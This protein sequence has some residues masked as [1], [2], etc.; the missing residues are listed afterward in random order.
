MTTEELRDALAARC[1]LVGWWVNAERMP[2]PDPRDVVKVIWAVRLGEG[3]ARGES[4]LESRYIAHCGDNLPKRV[5]EAVAA[6]VGKVLTGERPVL[7]TRV[8]K[9]KTA[10]DECP[11]TMPT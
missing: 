5:I 6:E 1:P 11:R 4:I 2:N 8:K 7:K 3:V 9:G 10:G